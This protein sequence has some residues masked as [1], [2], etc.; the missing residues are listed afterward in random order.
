MTDHSKL[1]CGIWRLRFVADCRVAKAA[2]EVPNHLD[3]PAQSS[4][5]EGMQPESSESRERKQ[6]GRKPRLRYGFAV[7]WTP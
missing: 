2:V 5:R 6:A 7:S 3:E 1:Q 4:G